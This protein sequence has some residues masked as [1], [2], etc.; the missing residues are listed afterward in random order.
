M[1]N[2]ETRE[3]MDYDYVKRT[4]EYLIDRLR[5]LLSTKNLSSIDIIYWNQA[6]MFLKT[7]TQQHLD[8]IKKLWIA[9]VVVF[10]LLSYSIIITLL[11]FTN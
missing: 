9:Y 3:Y 4:W 1:E 2:K 5:A 6:Y 10:I 11:Y 7:L 8:L